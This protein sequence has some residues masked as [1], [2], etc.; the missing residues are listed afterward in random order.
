MLAVLISL[1][2]GRISVGSICI[3]VSSDWSCQKPKNHVFIILNKWNSI[4]SHLIDEDWQLTPT[5]AANKT[6]TC[7]VIFSLKCSILTTIGSCTT[8]MMVCVCLLWQRLRHWFLP[9]ATSNHLL[10]AS[11]AQKFWVRIKVQAALWMSASL[12]SLP[13]T[14]L[15]PR[16]FL[17][18]LCSGETPAKTQQLANE[19]PEL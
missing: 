2:F 17:F 5:R 19:S 1:N 10:S 11:S 14:R 8:S 13:L 7:A 9:I 6:H 3:S 16:N 4:F 15:Q 12:A 18:N